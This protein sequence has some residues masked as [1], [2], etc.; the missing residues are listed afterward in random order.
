MTVQLSPTCS[1]GLEDHREAIERLQ[2]T[3]KAAAKQVRAQLRELAQLLAD[4]HLRSD[5]VDPV[6]FFH[7]DDGD[8]EFM[9]VLANQLSPQV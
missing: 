4:C 1:V 2:H 6:A 9:N 7:R 8:T 5:P 3:S